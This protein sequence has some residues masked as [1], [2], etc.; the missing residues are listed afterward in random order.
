[1]A[2]KPFRIAI[3]MAGAI[4]AGAYTAGVLDFLIEALEEWQSAK[5]ALR[6]YITNP[7]AGAVP[8]L[9][10]LHNVLI[11]MF[12]GASAGGM[13]AAIGSVMVQQPFQHIVT[14]DEQNTSN[15]FYESWVNQIDIRKLLDTRDVA[16]GKPL[17]SLL[18]ST[19][20][21][22][23]ASYALTPGN[24]ET[25]PYIAPNLTLFLSLTNVQGTLYPLYSDPAPTVDEFTEYYGDRLRF[26][27]TSGNT[28]TSIPTAKPLP[29]GMPQSGAWPLLQEA[30]KATGAVP[31]VLASRILPRDAGDYSI[32]GWSSF[33]DSSSSLSCARPV[34]PPPE[35][36]TLN[37][38]GGVTD[39]NPFQL[40]Y[41]YLSANTADRTI[42][43]EPDAACAAVLTVAPFPMAANPK[44]NYDPTANQ[45][46]WSILVN[47][48]GIAISQSRFLGE[49]LPDLMRGDTFSHFVLAPVDSDNPN[50]LA[51]QC[52]TL[53]AFGGFFSREFRKHDFLLGR[54]NCQQFLRSHFCLLAANPV[55]EGGTGRCCRVSARHQTEVP[56]GPTNW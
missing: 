29:K 31:V 11:E 8:P 21:D 2:D 33:A 24:P 38:D 41:D 13:C 47:T 55:I 17:L 50:T 15:A 3:N 19:I 56:T 22:E 1:M 12:T 6:S 53:G 34:A 7:S 39:N 43:P 32:P 35:W 54:R 42:P 18:D 27:T 23:I 10:P 5:D 44:G 30:A 48:F 51:L 25:R 37:V 20:I 36:Q 16:N 46:I 26:E 9:V 52:G 28:P 4:S 49:S 14:G 45:N 40:A